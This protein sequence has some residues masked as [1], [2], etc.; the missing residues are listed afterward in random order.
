VPTLITLLGEIDK[1]SIPLLAAYL[2]RRQPRWREEAPAGNRHHLVGQ[3]AADVGE[4][5]PIAWWQYDAG[6]LRWPGYERAHAAS[7]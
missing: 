7:Q 4:A 6:S 3:I 5:R 1:D 2:D